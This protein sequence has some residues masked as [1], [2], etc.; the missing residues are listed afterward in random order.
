MTQPSLTKG[1]GA[2]TG[3][4]LE[5]ASRAST[6]ATF[7]KAALGSG[8]PPPASEPNW[9]LA[10]HVDDSV[11]I[12]AEAAQGLWRGESSKPLLGMAAGDQGS[13]GD[14][15]AAD[16]SPECARFAQDL[17]ADLGEVLRAGCQPTTAQ[18]SALMDNPLGNVAMLFT[19]LDLWRLE[20]PTTGKTGNKWNYMG[21]AQFP[22]AIN[23]DWNLINR[24]VWNVPSMPLDQ[25]KIDRAVDK[26]S[27]LFGSGTGGTV[28]PPRRPT[29]GVEPLDVFGGRTT[30]FGDLYYVGLLSPKKG[31]K[32]DGGGTVVWGLGFDM[33]FP[34]ATDDIL[35]TGKWQ[36]GPSALAAYLG[37]KW[38]VG[39]LVQ[40]YWDFAGDD[41]R[42]DVN[43]TNFQYLY[44]YSLDPV[45]SI[46]AMPN[47]IINWEQGSLDNA[48]TL[49]VGLGINRTFQVG[50]VPVRVGVEFHYSVVQPDDVVGSEW[51]FRFY[52]V[53][54]APSAL[55]EWMTKPLFGG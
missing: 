46:G 25:D 48:L 12:G 7:Y 8:S 2:S 37:P 3:G 38:K 40:H 51:D 30:G 36:A 41:D 5:V 50:K 42:D 23:K 21:I 55:F 28:L 26:A 54:A 34:T 35:G 16:L 20:N 13:A 47:V 32:L 9:R 6:E 11:G 52:I 4:M 14:E 39:G 17:D 10:T 24:V 22:K 29:P 44:Y 27:G 18:M 1:K 53:P 31:I 45:T 19:Q 49:P 15:P 33:G 43:L